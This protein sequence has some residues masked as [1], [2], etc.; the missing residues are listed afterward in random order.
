MSNSSSLSIK[1]H[2]AQIDRDLYKKHM[3]DELLN[4][5]P[6]LTVLAEAVKNLIYVEDE[7]NEDSN[8]TKYKVL[9]VVLGKTSFKLF[10]IS[11]LQS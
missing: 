8:E 6:N 2:R 10:F 4:K 7:K 1:G 9:G 3:Q 11:T 5:T